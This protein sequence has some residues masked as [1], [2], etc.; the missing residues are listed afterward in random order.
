MVEQDAAGDM[1]VHQIKDLRQAAA[2]KPKDL[3]L[4]QS[5]PA[6]L[7]EPLAIDDVVLPAL[8]EQNQ[9][10]LFQLNTPTISHSHPLILRISGD[11]ILPT[12][13]CWASDQPATQHALHRGALSKRLQSN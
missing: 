6:H 11:K 5:P 12:Y 3:S 7:T 2:L 10:I 4:I 13:L 8:G 1:R 9:A